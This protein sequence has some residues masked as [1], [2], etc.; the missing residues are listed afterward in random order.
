MLFKYNLLN[1]FWYWHEKVQGNVGKMLTKN[2]IYSVK[3][4]WKININ[5]KLLML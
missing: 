2:E 5:L 4:F 3:G 1:L